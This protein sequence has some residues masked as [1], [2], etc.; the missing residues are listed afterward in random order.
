[1]RQE[2]NNDRWSTDGMMERAVGV[3]MMMMM[4]MGEVGDDRASH[5][6]PRTTQ[7][8]QVRWCE[9][10]LCSTRNAD[11]YLKSRSVESSTRMKRCAVELL[12]VSQTNSKQLPII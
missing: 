6:A 3:M 4:M 9:T 7:L 2:R 8:M 12:A 1:L 5:A 10:V 11:I